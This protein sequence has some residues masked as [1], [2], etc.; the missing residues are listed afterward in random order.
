VGGF[1]IFTRMA[2]IKALWR[3]KV[4]T[5]KGR[6]KEKSPLGITLAIL[7]YLTLVGIVIAVTV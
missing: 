2:T 5:T 6:Q 1:F 4:I 7:L 3:L